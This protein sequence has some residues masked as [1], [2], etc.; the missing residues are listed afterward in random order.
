MSDAVARMNVNSDTNLAEGDNNKKH[1]GINNSSN[2]C[3]KATIFDHNAP[4]AAF[5]DDSD[6][7]VEYAQVKDVYG[8]EGNN[9]DQM[10]TLP[11]DMTPS[12]SKTRHRREK[13]Q[14][15]CFI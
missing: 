1:L 11:H 10:Y 5:E 7:M 14:S 15:K 2:T 3:N 13:E 8:D 9:V 12:K 6:D 4:L